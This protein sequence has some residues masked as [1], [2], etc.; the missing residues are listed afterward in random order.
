MYAIYS[1][2][3]IIEN[4][5]GRSGSLAVLSACRQVGSAVHPKAVV[6]KP[7]FSGS[8]ISPNGQK[9]KLTTMLCGAKE[10]QR[11]LR[12]NERIVS[13]FTT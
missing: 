11:S 5:N 2:Q 13:C 6:H 1:H 10:A 7:L 4:P 3:L 9:Q 12:P 8:F